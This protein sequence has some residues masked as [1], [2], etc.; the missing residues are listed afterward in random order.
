MDQMLSILTKQAQAPTVAAYNPVMSNNPS[1]SPQGN[2]IHK[3]EVM[4]MI[5]QELRQTNQS[6]TNR[7]LFDGHPICDYC[8]TVR[9]I[10]YACRQRS[11]QNRDPRIPN[12]N[13]R[14][15]F[16]SHQRYSGQSCRPMNQQHLN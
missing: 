3:T 15:N 6:Q 14:S 10:A 13:K 7:M 9:H 4:Q 2:M 11:N 1:R 12:Y 8:N 16:N 5:R